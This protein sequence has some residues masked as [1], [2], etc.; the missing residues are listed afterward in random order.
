MFSLKEKIKAEIGIPP[1]LQLLLYRGKLLDQKCIINF[2]QYEN[3]HLLVKGKGG[4]QCSEL[5]KKAF[6]FMI[7]RTL[8]IL[9]VYSKFNK[10][11]TFQ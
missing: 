9:I 5:G 6:L 1:D 7:N 2:N 3:I 11:V 8:N 10:N 4:M